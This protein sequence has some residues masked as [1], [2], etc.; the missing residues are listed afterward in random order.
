MCDF[1]SFLS[2]LEREEEE[3][4][5]SMKKL[6]VHSVSGFCCY[7]ISLE[8]KY[9]TPP[10]VY[11]VPDPMT[12]FYD[13][14]ME[15][16][17]VISKIVS[18]QVPMRPM[19]SDKHKLHEAATECVNCGGLFSDRNLKV[20]HHDH[21]S[22]EYLFPACQKCNLQLKLR[23]AGKNLNIVRMGR[24]NTKKISFYQYC[25]TIVKIMTPTSCWSTLRSTPSIMAKTVVCRS[26]T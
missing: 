24:R 22:G 21:V 14:V 9:R 5:N 15:E 1:E 6:D 19:T 8:P 26:T 4:R 13:H 11:S 17:R 16:S 25:F 18:R 20:H 7:R 3:E 10:K 2:P 12:E 23:K